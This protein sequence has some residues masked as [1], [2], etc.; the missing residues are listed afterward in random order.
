MLL[1]S[2]NEALDLLLQGYTYV[3]V[4]SEPEFALGRPAVIQNGVSLNVAW[5]VPWQRVAG[6]RLID[7]PDFARVVQGVFGKE[8]P[9]IVGC[10]SGSRS[11][12]AIAALQGL[13]FTKLAQL[14]NGFEGARDAFGRLV[15]G[16]RQSGLDVEVGEPPLD[17]SYAGL[18]V[19]AQVCS[20]V[21]ACR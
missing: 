8:Q 3:D 14:R 16:W 18:C 11:R 6:D 17:R 10:R 20:S 19:V 2:P 12:A 15:P 7:N 4:R 13:G 1:V 21:P 5:N 9:L